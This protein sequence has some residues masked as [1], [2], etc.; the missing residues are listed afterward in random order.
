MIKSITGYGRAERHNDQ[1]TI[2]AEIK[3][4]NSKQMALYARIP[5]HYKEKDYE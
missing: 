2:T 5:S 3:S 4:M 1:R